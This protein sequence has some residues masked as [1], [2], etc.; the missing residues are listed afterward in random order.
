MSGVI[1]VYQVNKYIKNMLAEDFLLGS[2]SVKGEVSNCKYHP[3]GHIYFTLKD[4]SAAM[5]CVMFAGNRAGLTFSMK[6][7]DK[8]VVSGHVDV[9][10]KAGTYQLYASK[11]RLE[12]AGDLY[13]RFLKLKAQLEEMGMFAP[14]YKKPIPKHV[15]NIGV[16]TA[17][18]GAAIRDIQN[19]VRRRD[20]GVQIILFPA[21]VQGE[22]A[23]ESI[24]KG[25]QV[26][27][28]TGVD[29]IIVGRGGG[30]IEDLWAFNEEIVARAI[31]DC[32]TPV[33][34]AVGHETD[35][36]IA[37]F[38]ADMRAPTPS[39]AAEIATQNIFDTMEKLNA[40]ERRIRFCMS[41]KLELTKADLKQYTGRIEAHRPDRIIE[42]YREKLRYYRTRISSCTEKTMADKKHTLAVLA[43]R[44]D[45]LSPLKRLKA[46]FS[47][48]S[49][50]SG[51]AL[52][53]VEKVKN[54]DILDIALRDGRIKASVTDVEKGVLS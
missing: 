13:E 33:I 11:I 14:E 37:D 48:V 3:S 25:L 7:G 26:L 10:E 47:Y 6:N 31:F 41:R 46:G 39:A 20:P 49:L 54:G 9:Y 17:P 36:T 22:N 28:R 42:G 4:E 1:S 18:T 34:S 5:N 16:V 30:S 53:S 35:F 27:D 15:K 29:V 51:E 38:V 45:A 32:E 44:L 23:K 24:V 12:G 2:L 40:C 19:I 8:V 43:E 52:K 50:E 21:L